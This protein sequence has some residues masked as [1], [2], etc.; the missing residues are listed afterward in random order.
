MPQNN[1]TAQIGQQLLY[2]LDDPT[3][4]FRNAL[5][6][7]GI[8]PYRSNPFVTALQKQAQGA[9]I[10]FLADRART[11]NAVNTPGVSN[12]SQAYGEFLKSNLGRGDLL[13]QMG[14]DAGNFGSI[15]QT[16]RDFESGLSNGSLQAA[17][18]PYAAGLRDI[19]AGDNG[20]GAMS[21]YA[22]LRTPGLGS[23]AAP[24]TRALSNVA[25]Q[26]SRRFAQQGGLNDDV[27]QW[28]FPSGSVF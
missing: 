27:W 17:S 8:N 9:R 1:D 15:L 26:S 20:Q 11:P 6:D 25:D 18:N 13:G 21:A 23:L 7:M 16:V 19:F 14:R 3:T 10:S 24:Y 12:P 22:S 5:Q 2:P 28:M 4:A